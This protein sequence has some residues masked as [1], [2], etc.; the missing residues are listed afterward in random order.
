ML[1][2]KVAQQVVLGLPLCLIAKGLRIAA[3]LKNPATDTA[4]L[5][6]GRAGPGHKGPAQLFGFC[7]RYHDAYSLEDQVFSP[8][9]SGPPL[10][11]RIP[12][13]T[14]SGFLP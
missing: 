7:R 14:K 10:G 8:R 6:R 11:K 9:H 5:Y 12:G 13:H 1:C 3:L 2:A 4:G